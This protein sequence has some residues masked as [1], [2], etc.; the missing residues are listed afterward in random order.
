MCVGRSRVGW[1]VDYWPTVPSTA[2]RRRSRS[3]QWRA[4]S[5]IMCRSAYRSA[6]SMSGPRARS[7][8][9]LDRH[10]TYI[11][12]AFIGGSTCGARWSTPHWSIA[13]NADRLP[14][15][16]SA[17]AAGDRP[18]Q[19]EVLDVPVRLLVGRHP[20]R[21][22]VVTA[23]TPSHCPWTEAHVDTPPRGVCRSGTSV[24]ARP[25]FSA[26][27]SVV[28]EGGPAVRADACRSAYQSSRP[29]PSC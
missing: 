12:S 5:S 16:R 10:A 3:P 11:V 28:W 7:R 25:P 21:L 15:R 1:P 22:V 23:P 6:N 14:T 18:Q 4:I 9:S 29:T 20:E 13:G 27:K 8:R 19:S 17:D 2:S 26:G 24:S